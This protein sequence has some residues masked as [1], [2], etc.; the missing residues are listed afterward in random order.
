MKDL[1][2]LD[3]VAYLFRSYYAIRGMTN[4]KGEPTNALY[5]FIRSVEKIQ[6]DF[7]IARDM[8]D[9]KALT[10]GERISFASDILTSQL[11]ILENYY[12]QYEILI[13]VLDLKG[14]FSDMFE[15]ETAAQ[16]RTL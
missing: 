11:R 7:D 15:I 9:L 13:D 3:A 8:T 4:A 14:G 6:K 5:G 1:Y 16:R 12:Q 10:F 2:I